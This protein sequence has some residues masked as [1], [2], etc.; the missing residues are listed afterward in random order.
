M[1]RWASMLALSWA[2]CSGAASAQGGRPLPAC[3]GI[4]PRTLPDARVC[5]VRWLPSHEDGRDPFD[6][7]IALSDAH[8]DAEKLSDAEEVL[9]CAAAQITDGSD[10]QRRY[11]IVR[12]YGVLD[13]KRDDIAVA[14]S[15]FDC[16]LAIA[17]EIDDRPAVIK[18]LKNAGSARRRLGDYKTALA[19]SLRSLE[20]QEADGDPATGAV[21]N[22]IADIHRDSGRL[23][24]AQAY[25]ARALAVFRRV[26]N[27]I[28]AMHV[29]EMLANLALDRD[30]PATATR[31]LETALG[32]LRDAGNRKYRLRIYAALARTAIAQGDAERARRYCADG[33]ALASESGLSLPWELQLETARADR[34]SGRLAPALARLRAAL[35]HAP[36]GDL[37]EAALRN[38]L[39]LTLRE[40]GDD[41]EAM[42]A[43]SAAHALELQDMRRQS[44]RQVLW[45]WDHFSAKERE[46]ENATLRAQNRQRTLMLWLTAVSALAALLV[47]SLFFLRRQQRARIA[48]AANRARYEEHI[49]RY[50][51]ESAAL[52]EDRDLLQTLLDSRDDAICLVDTEGAVLA[53]N[54]AAC[55]ALGAE[56]QVLE[57][58]PLPDRFA[59]EDAAALKTALERME[60]A[61]TQSIVIA[62][63]ADLP[64]LRADLRQW[65]G[66]DGL[67][68]VALQAESSLA[69]DTSAVADVASL[70]SARARTADRAVVNAQSAAPDAALGAASHAENGVVDGVVNEAAP[71]APLR[72]S[73]FAARPAYLAG[74]AEAREEFRRALVA[75]ML[76]VVDTWERSTNT[77][78]IEL[79]ERSRIW[80]VNIDDGRLRARAMERYLGVSKLPEN[81]RWRD[82]L[83]TAYF[84][85]AQCPLEPAQREEL[86]SLV[87][88]VVAYT[89]RSAM[90]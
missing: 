68:V 51:R 13:Y 28:E 67:I 53:A 46:R 39:A 62:A 7:L 65:E 88:A 26:G 64:A 8:R 14:L 80:R 34:L 11:E 78:R 70:E 69:S 36:E 35:D 49:A 48:E 16:A 52:A 12:R 89:R 33:L 23:A 47:L 81:P 54:R 38:E 1:L 60:D 10:S 55:I 25:Y 37:A 59:S 45:L 9:A 74:G 19:Q 18:Q 82:V 32:E 73:S 50:R 2:I 83:R 66:G 90:M 24:Q 5:T 20:M 75:L 42:D 6:A 72:A 31:L 58:Q 40:N 77:N 27:T 43:L 87:D 3:V 17:N 41:A 29:Y 56:R 57:T 79:A 21:L 44:D 63:T 15:R 86:Q 30:D 84:V 85:L 71:A 76:A 22:N 61:Q 4:D